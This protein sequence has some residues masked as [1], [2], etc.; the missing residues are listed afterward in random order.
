MSNIKKNQVMFT[1]T[2]KI[3][4]SSSFHNI[5]QRTIIK[6]F[7][8]RYGYN[9]EVLFLNNFENAPFYFNEN[10]L[11]KLSLNDKP[12]VDI[13]AY[14]KEKNWLYLIENAYS[15]RI[16]DETRLSVLKKYSRNFKGHVIYITVFPNKEALRKSSTDIAWE[17][18]VWIADNPDHLIHFNGDKFLGPYKKSC[19]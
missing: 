17:T 11:K 6:E 9:S 2:D 18:E 16:I 19:K 10:S 15:D 13:I 5:L 4:F 14:S 8:S 3:S 12:K 1:N 7:L